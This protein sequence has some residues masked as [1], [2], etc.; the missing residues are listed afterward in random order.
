M[1][2]KKSSHYTGSFYACLEVIFEGIRWILDQKRA[3]QL[4]IYTYYALNFQ[5]SFKTF[6]Q[7]PEF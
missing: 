1:R 6:S 5:F 2:I 4:Q 7:I 3:L